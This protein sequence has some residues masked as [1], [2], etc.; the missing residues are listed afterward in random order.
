M[1]TNSY[2]QS[3]KPFSLIEFNKSRLFSVQFPFISASATV[4]SH[5]WVSIRYSK[6]IL[7]VSWKQSYDI[8]E[9]APKISDTAVVFLKAEATFTKKD[10]LLTSF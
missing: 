3:A 2:N 1:K 5:C 8:K 6:R 4:Q 7:S 9:A 10:S